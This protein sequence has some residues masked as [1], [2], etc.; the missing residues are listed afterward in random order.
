MESVVS[1][2]DLENKLW[3]REKYW[4]CQLFTNTH[5]MNSVSDL[6]VSKEK[7]VEKS[8][9]ILSIMLYLFV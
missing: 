1:E 6:Y 4:Q 5:G 2:L 9:V 8:N 7:D 3:E